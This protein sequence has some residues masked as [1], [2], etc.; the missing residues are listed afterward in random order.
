MTKET[1]QSKMGTEVTRTKS[2]LAQALTGAIDG[3]GLYSREDWGFILGVS[4]AAISQWLSDT[5]LPRPEMLRMIL[6]AL[7]ESPGVPP[8]V[9][10]AF[11]A[12]RYRPATEISPHGARMA[13]SLAHY[14]ARPLREGLF[15]ELDALS[16]DS[17]EQVLAA[18]RR[19]CRDAVRRKA[20]VKPEP[21]SATAPADAAPA[22]E[23]A[24][25]AMRAPFTRADLM[26]LTVEE[27]VDLNP[28]AWVV[29]GARQS[30]L[31]G[32]P[33]RLRVVGQEEPSFNIIS[34]MFSAS[35]EQQDALGEDELLTCAVLI[36]V[37]PRSATPFPA[38]LVEEAEIFLYSGRIK[39]TLAG[40][41]DPIILGNEPG[42]SNLMW[43][44][45]GRQN[46]LGLPPFECVPLS[47]EPAVGIAV[48]YDSKGVRLNPAASGVS[49][50]Y[51]VRPEARED[52]DAA[53]A[54]R[55]WRELRAEQPSLADR[56]PMLAR[57]PNG[58][59]DLHAMLEENR[60]SEDERD[61]NHLD[62]RCKEQLDD[63]NIP[64][65]AVPKS[66]ALHTRLMRFP[67]CPGV[68]EKD[69][70]AASH[71]GQEIIIPLEGAFNCVYANLLPSE[72]EKSKFKM[73]F[74]SPDRR[75]HKNVQSTAV[76]RQVFPD[77]FFINSESAHGFYGANGDAY[78]LHVR[79]LPDLT[80][81]RPR[82]QGAGAHTARPSRKSRRGVA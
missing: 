62:A 61:D 47:N 46:D 21:E 73:E 6:D 45:A 27:T 7:K 76:S 40:R 53:A 75:R 71:P 10:A 81:I 19:L 59:K 79:C 77:L 51:L 34:G 82:Y 43:L 38:F 65:W 24:E 70:L 14:L 74:F 64:R 32:T 56:L 5:T 25:T 42:D 72:A 17:Q 28:T 35:N 18:A 20:V 66:A 50:P 48:L 37:F 15:R 33:P 55:Y 3:A 67:E 4:E 63:A 26:A 9:T 1:N 78:C 8:E 23:V 58:R 52:W 11:D 36:W 41:R 44:T 80:R 31:V 60:L 54:E 57:V 22:H 16:P 29:T 69:I 30:A 2:L 39:L 13:G 49:N 68:M 12:L